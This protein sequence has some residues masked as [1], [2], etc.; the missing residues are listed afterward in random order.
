MSHSCPHR[1]ESLGVM[2]CDCAECSEARKYWEDWASRQCAGCLY[3]AHIY[4]QNRLIDTH[5]AADPNDLL[6]KF[7]TPEQF[8]ALQSYVKELQAMPP[9]QGRMQ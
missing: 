9:T 2:S 4:T 1:R 3:L 7:M 8:L 5:L 6:K